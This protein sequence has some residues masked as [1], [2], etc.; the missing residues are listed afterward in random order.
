MFVCMQTWSGILMN[1]KIHIHWANLKE[2]IKEEVI[3]RYLD[4]LT[5]VLWENE[6]RLRH[7]CGLEREL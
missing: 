4:I 5:T 6:Q 7:E 2:G 1:L 3:W